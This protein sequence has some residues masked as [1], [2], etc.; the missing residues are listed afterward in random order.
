MAASDKLTITVNG[1]QRE[2]FMSFALLSS[3]VRVV[4]SVDDLGQA[5]L[6]PSVRD[7]LVVV[8]LAPRDGEKKLEDYSVADFNLSVQD[9]DRLV[10][11]IMEHVLDFFMKRIEM[12]KN[13]SESETGKKLESLMSSIAGSLASRSKKPSSGRS[14]SKEATST[15]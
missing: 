6:D 4:G 3:M 13:L 11:W 10:D 12:A 7:A 1:Q 14:A 5:I 15:T 2:V 8:A 9:G